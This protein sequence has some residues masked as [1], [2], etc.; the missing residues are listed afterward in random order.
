MDRFVKRYIAKDE[1]EIGDAVYFEHTGDSSNIFVGES[2]F[3]ATK[4]LL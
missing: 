4:T 3:L 2:Y 1:A